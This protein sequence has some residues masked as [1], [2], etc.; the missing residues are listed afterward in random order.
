[1][2]KINALI[3]EQEVGI[4]KADSIILSYKEN[5]A[6]KVEVFGKTIHRYIKNQNKRY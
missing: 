3:N 1:M 4:E 5:E 6:L 2:A